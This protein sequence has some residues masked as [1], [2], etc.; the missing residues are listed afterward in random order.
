MRLHHA[1][2]T[3]S[4]GLLIETATSLNLQSVLLQ[5]IHGD[6]TTITSCEYLAERVY[7][8]PRSSVAVKVIYEDYRNL[9]LVTV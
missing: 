7:E 9:G 6:L 1:H 3:R 2:S 5:K 8:V 4:G